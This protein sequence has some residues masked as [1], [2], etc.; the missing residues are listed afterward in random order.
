MALQHTEIAKK[1]YASKAWK[2][3]RKAYIDSLDNGGMCKKCLEY[4]IYKHGY[5]VDHIIPIDINN[6][7]NP[8]I[9]LNWNNLQYLCIECHNKKTFGNEEVFDAIPEGTMFDENGQLIKR[10][11]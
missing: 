9:T 6:I 5:I 3:T 8:E 10:E 1:F 2:K 4:G 11:D 7:D